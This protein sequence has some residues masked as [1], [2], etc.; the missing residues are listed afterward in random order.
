MK[1]YEK[2]VVVI[3]HFELSH[4]VANCSPAMGHSK[5]QCKYE[6]NELFG[7]LNGAETVFSGDCTYTIDEFTT[8]FEGF[9]LQTSEDG[10]NLFTS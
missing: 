4:S 6:S 1:K 7:M 3:E 8:M 2:P 9:C 5:E 10:M